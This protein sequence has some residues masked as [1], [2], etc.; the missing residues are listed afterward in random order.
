MLPS[1]WHLLRWLCR[2]ER[3][4][5]IEFGREEGW[6]GPSWDRLQRGVVKMSETIVEFLT[7]GPYC[8][9]YEIAFE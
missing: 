7:V 4:V 5:G 2:R 3:R 1:C 9:E 8:P 6:Y